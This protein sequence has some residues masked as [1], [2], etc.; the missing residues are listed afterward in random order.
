MRIILAVDVPEIRDPDSDAATFRIAEIES[1]G[2]RLAPG[3]R[4]W[5]IQDVTGEPAGSA[6]ESLADR[7]ERETLDA[8]RFS[9]NTVRYWFEWFRA[10]GTF[11]PDAAAAVAWI[12]EREEMIGR[13]LTLPDAWIPAD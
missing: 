4:A 9:P 13:G 7:V 2:I 1:E 3:D 5:W 8:G 10:R 12:G 11:P 6:G